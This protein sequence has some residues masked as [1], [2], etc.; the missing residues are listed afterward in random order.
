VGAPLAN[1]S[2][3]PWPTS[4]DARVAAE[5]AV[6]GSLSGY[7]A[8]ALGCGAGG[9]TC[10]IDQAPAADCASGHRCIVVT[11]S[12]PYRSRPLLAGM[13]SEIPPFDLVL[14]PDLEFTSVVQ[15]S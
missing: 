1:C 9:L 8:G 14:P 5:T 11:L 3:P 12:Y 7:R 2:T 10:T 13:P 15:V 6:R 4:C